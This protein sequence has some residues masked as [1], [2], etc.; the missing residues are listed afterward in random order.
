MNS[1]NPKG[2]LV[3]HQVGIESIVWFPD[4]KTI[5]SADSAGRV[6]IWDLSTR[7]YVLSRRFDDVTRMEVI[8][9]TQTLATLPRYAGANLDLWYGHP[10]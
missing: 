5:A 3:G 1:R 4:L 2:V 6:L 7:Q 10:N 9:R 8:P